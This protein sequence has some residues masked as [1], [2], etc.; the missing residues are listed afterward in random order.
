[1]L[2]KTLSM[3]LVVLVINLAALPSVFANGSNPEKEA[4]FAAKVKAEILKLGAGTESKVKIKLKD[5]T[6]L[7][8]YLS[9]ISETGFVVT[10]ETGKSNTVPYP[11]VKQA[12]GGNT[13]TGWSIVGGNV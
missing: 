9:E 4:K 5:G 8:G 13:K 3:L 7:K 12:S 2:K 6:K 11:S 10:D 1:M